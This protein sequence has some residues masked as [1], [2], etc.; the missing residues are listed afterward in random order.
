MYFVNKLK[1]GNNVEEL[2][3]DFSTEYG[4]NLKYKT[5]YLED[6]IVFSIICEKYGQIASYLLK[7]FEF[8]ELSGKSIVI[9]EMFGVAYEKSRKIYLKFMKHN[10]KDYKEAYI[11]NAKDIARQATIEIISL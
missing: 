7:D 8:I 10:F 6:G 4:K 2:I 5:L 3:S 1:E 11:Q 9:E